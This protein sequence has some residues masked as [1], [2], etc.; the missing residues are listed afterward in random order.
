MPL[1]YIMLTI[2]NCSALYVSFMLI[3]SA[4]LK[5]KLGLINFADMVSA[6][7]LMPSSASVPIAWIIFGGEVIAAATLLVP[8]WHRY[9]GL[10]LSLLGIIFLGAQTS[11]LYRKMDIMCG[12]H[13][14]DS[15]PVTWK[16]L[17]LPFLFAVLGIILVSLSDSFFNQYAA[18]G[19][20]P[21]ICGIV[22]CWA[23]FLY[24]KSKRI[25]DNSQN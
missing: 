24:Q 14:A 13:G 11:V 9:S 16:T 22:V 1:K 10:L 12:C 2:L 20:K 7:R 18:F 5:Y 19:F 21:T 4:C 3:K 15:E 8:H 6:Y 25:M 17:P 23:I